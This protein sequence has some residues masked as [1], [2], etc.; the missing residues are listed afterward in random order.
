M[1]KKEFMK[2]L[3]DRLRFL[4]DEERKDIL[5]DYED[6]FSAAMENGEQEEDIVK[7]LGSPEIIARQYK[8][9]RVIQ[10]AETNKTSGNLMR[11][12][13]ATMGLGFLN[14]V[15]VIGPFFGIVGVLIGFYAAAFG[16]GI[17]GLAVAGA[18][19]IGLIT[20]TLG[21]FV[22]L[23][24][25]INFND[26]YLSIVLLSFGV[27]LGSIGGLFGIGTFYLTKVFYNLTVKYLKFNVK[28]IKGNE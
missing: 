12:V 23:P 27:S 28:L 16:L 13:L 10:Q 26:S 3:E 18:G 7:S 14:M 15:F 6:H 1:N 8:V 5:F 9:S 25:G 19:L 22:H 20:G 2:R 21:P 17:S 4:A 11:A 24:V